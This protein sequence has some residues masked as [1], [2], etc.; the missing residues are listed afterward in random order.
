ML[1]RAR[2][3]GGL[4]YTETGESKIIAVL[5]SIISLILK[6]EPKGDE[7]YLKLNLTLTNT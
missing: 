5:T 3:K 4:G 2:L 7:D 6:E 1:Y